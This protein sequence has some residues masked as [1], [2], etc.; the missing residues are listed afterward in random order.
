MRRH[1]S[2]LSFVVGVG[3]VCTISAQQAAPTQGRQGGGGRGGGGGTGAARASAAALVLDVNWVRPA[4]QTGQTK[5]V[6]ENIG[7]AD[8]E[9][10]QY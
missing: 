10:K 6:Q 8:L 7:G 9:L 4:S 2:M 5:V 3:L 1:V